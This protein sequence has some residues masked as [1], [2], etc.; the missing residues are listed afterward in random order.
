MTDRDAILDSLERVRRRWR[1]RL[2][3]EAGVWAG[4]AVLGIGLVWFLVGRVGLS[5]PVVDGVRVALW[6]GLAGVLGVLIVRTV[7]RR[8]DDA[9]VAL[10]LEEHEPEL[11]QSL[12][13]AVDV[14]RGEPG[15][16]SPMLVERLLTVTRQRL[17]TAEY[18]RR[19]DR[20]R[21][22]RAAGTLATMTLGS[23]ALLLL[24]PTSLRTSATTLFDPRSH[25]PVVEPFSVSVDPGNATVPKGGAQAI[26]AV[27]GGFSSE[28]ADLVF[29]SDSAGEWE[30]IPME[31]DSLAGR[32]LSRLFDVSK[33][34][35]YYV[36]ADGVRSPAFRLDVVD[37]PAVRRLQAT[38]RYPA[39]T[40]LPAETIEDAGDLAVLK[41]A[42]VTIHATTTRP[43]RGASLVVLDGA[44]IA[45]NASSGGAFDGTFRATADGFYRID[46]IAADGREVRGSLEYAI[47]VLE[48]S[49]PTVRVTEPGRDT[50]VTSIEEVMTRVEAADDYGVRNVRLHLT[51]NGGPE[52]VVSVVDSAVGSRKEVSAGHTLFLEEW[53]LTPGDLISYYAEAS[54]GLGQSA[55]SDLYFLD[56]RP[57][58]K[59]YREADQQGGGGGGD[60]NTPEGLS[61][62]QK[63]VIVGTFNV[64]RDSATQVDRVWRENLTTLAISQGRLRE[65][66]AELVGRMKQ[67]N[68]AHVDSTFALIA[69]ELDSAEQVMR[70]AEEGLGRQRPREAMPDEEKALRHLQRAE[71]A[72]RETQ[73]S[74]GGGGGGGGGGSQANAEDLADLFELQTD[75]LK[76]QYESVQQESSRRSES[77]LDETLERLRRLAS[78]QQQENERMQR[79]AD[80]LRNRSGR[81]GGGG[82]SQR[83]LAQETEEAARQLERLSRERNDPGLAETARQLRQAA[84]AMRKAAAGGAQQGGAQ[85]D[86]ALDR[87]KQATKGLERARQ[88]GR[89]EQIRQLADQADELRRRQQDVGRDARQLPSDPTA[90]NERIAAVRAR[91]DELAREV[92][93]L[94]SEA[95]RLAKSVGRD[96]PKASRDL[97]EAAEG[98]R[99]D[100]VRDKLAFS[101]GLVGRGA[102]EYLEN[103]EKSIGDNLGSAS[104]RLHRAAGSL[105]TP[106]GSREAAALDRARDLV[107]GLE[108]LRDRAR[109]AQ[110]RARQ[111]GEARQPD[112]AGKPGQAGQP[113]QPGRQPGE[114]DR[115]GASR[116][117]RP[118]RPGAG[119]V[120]P[121]GRAR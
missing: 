102:E 103:M 77:K 9:A 121:A 43:A 66:V 95:D 46:L 116:P 107:R 54:D 28:A 109:A 13:S 64:V 117:G 80:A 114:G 73:I 59:A 58:D 42:T 108:S 51:V 76:N 44:P 18:G 31:R 112:Q 27:L 106:A 67:R 41:G 55:R 98:L 26:A 75:K 48:D 53:S 70:R 4:A 14:I 16:A 38:I 89:R 105:E 10:Y 19:V 50:K 71:A 21:L 56:V 94:E 120:R 100:R 60:G 3:L 74:Q 47:D 2:V 82:G 115:A 72:Y 99:T 32:F 81:A 63:Q 1:L 15:P 96:Q 24:G 22:R 83:D 101:K 49:P 110:D 35:E 39:Y 111:D 87:L 78:R 20:R 30:R 23:V 84:E 61:E 25:A 45:M 62:Q 90:R 57:F 7:R 8:A 52:Q 79:M 17:E 33:P 6:V 68:V 97:S 93:Q 86:D 119:S 118:S 104:E 88:E 29:R 5:A 11:A 85:G 37:L 91:K 113:G 34:T 92:D 65:Q 12:L 36:E 69:T 40:G